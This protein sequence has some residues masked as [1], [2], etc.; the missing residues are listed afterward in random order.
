MIILT[1][2]FMTRG[3]SSGAIYDDNVYWL[4]AEQQ[5]ERRDIGFRR[6]KAWTMEIT[7]TCWESSAGW[8]A[9]QTEESGASYNREYRS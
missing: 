6:D 2:S 7:T 8:W 4:V 5:E 9:P 3:G 1:R